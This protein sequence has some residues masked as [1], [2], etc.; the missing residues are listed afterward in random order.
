MIVRQVGSRE[1]IRVLVWMDPD[2]GRG[3]RHRH[4]IVAVS[5]APETGAFSCTAMTDVGLPALQPQTAKLVHERRIRELIHAHAGRRDQAESLAAAIAVASFLRLTGHEGMRRGQA[6]SEPC[7]GGADVV[8]RFE[9]FL[10]RDSAP[11][12][13]TSPGSVL[14][15]LMVPSHAVVAGIENSILQDESGAVRPHRDFSISFHS[16]SCALEAAAAM[17][18]EMEGTGYRFPDGFRE[19]DLNAAA[20]ALGSVGAPTAQ[21]VA[22]YADAGAHRPGWRQQSASAYPLLAELMAQFDLSRTAID[23]ARPLQP[24]ISELTGL[25]KGKL[26]RL[27]RMRTPLPTGRVFEFGAEVRGEDP[28]GIDRARRYALGNELSLSQLLTLFADFDTSWVPSDE[29]SWIRF[30]AIVRGF[31]Q[32]VANRHSCS[33]DMFLKASRGNWS[34]MHQQLAAAYGCDPDEFDLRQVSMAASDVLEMIDDFTQSVVLPCALMELERQGLELPKPTARDLEVANR[35]A[36]TMLRAGAA[37]PSAALLGCVRRWLSRAPA[38]VAADAGRNEGNAADRENDEGQA[39]FAD[40]EDNPSWPS[41]T[42]DFRASNGLCVR[43]L[44]SEDDLREESCRLSHCVGRLYLPKAKRGDCHIYSVRDDSGS[45]SLCTFEVAPPG[46]EIDAIASSDIQI[47]QCK[48][49]RNRRPGSAAM[50]AVEDWEAA[51]KSGSLRLNLSEVCQWRNSAKADSRSMENGPRSPGS[52]WTAVL[53]RNWQDQEVRNAVWQEWRRHILR[54]ELA[55][56]EA[57]GSLF[58]KDPCHALIAQLSSLAPSD[59]GTA[60]AQQA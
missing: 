39:S 30:I 34:R 59:R 13:P 1:Q 7:G 18:K 46:S 44:A 9:S 2:L 8:S 25:S 40:K 31:V 32:P 35:L 26:K 57:P 48:A 10:N 21:A 37:N 56:V 20:K 19:L 27:G 38:L 14:K 16:G 60:D 12:P 6:G 45:R 15:H 28:L 23:E 52:A 5:A 41:L 50:K 33:A 49:K 22:F 54:G 3:S 42:A 17:A 11:S 53:G 43:N 58:S 24:A 4:D 51:V 55:R 36:F 29:E 47:V